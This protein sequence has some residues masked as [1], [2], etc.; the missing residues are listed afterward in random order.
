MFVLCIDMN[1]SP[2]TLPCARVPLVVDFL[3]ILSVGG[4]HFVFA[5]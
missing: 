3:P 1:L 2:L 5:A 4:A